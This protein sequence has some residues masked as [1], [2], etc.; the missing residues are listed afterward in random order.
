MSLGFLP[1]WRRFLSEGCRYRLSGIVSS[2][3]SAIIKFSKWNESKRIRNYLKIYNIAVLYY[4]IIRKHEKKHYKA[5]CTT[6][7]KESD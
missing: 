3:A 4:V 2:E 5:D 6:K 7:S 1:E